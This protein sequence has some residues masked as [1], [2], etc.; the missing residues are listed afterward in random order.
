MHGRA[1]ASSDTH[2]AASAKLAP[3]AASVVRVEE[4]DLDGGGGSLEASGCGRSASFRVAPGRACTGLR[5]SGRR[6]DGPA[7][8]Q[9]LSAKEATGP[10]VLRGRLTDPVRSRRLP[11]LDSVE[12]LCLSD[13]AFALALSEDDVSNACRTYAQAW[14][15][16]ARLARSSTT[17]R[18]QFAQSLF[19]NGLCQLIPLAW[20]VGAE[21]YS[22]ARSTRADG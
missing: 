16:T 19:G 1:G 12:G 5:R 17:V 15:R 3:T 20:A 2:L 7:R 22:D 4:D 18:D 10:A 11:A 8:E 9:L 21:D 13:L 6:P 14:C